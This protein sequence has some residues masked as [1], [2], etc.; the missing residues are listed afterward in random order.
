MALDVALPLE[1]LALPLAESTGER[2]A[3]VQPSG[4]LRTGQMP[5][6]ALLSLE[7]SDEKDAL[8]NL[9]EFL[10]ADESAS[11]PSEAQV[12]W[13][14]DRDGLLDPWSVM[15]LPMSSWPEE[16]RPFAE[17]LRP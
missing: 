11:K 9:L 4:S 17:L 16:L 7:T 12:D 14:L 1:V 10:S 6:E 8:E 2:P 5:V 15:I 3:P 13:D